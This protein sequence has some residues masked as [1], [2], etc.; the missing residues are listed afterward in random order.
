M[1]EYQ[2]PLVESNCSYLAGELQYHCMDTTELVVRER[3]GDLM[4]ETKGANSKV[5]TVQN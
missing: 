4:I 5:S 2:N 3:S 1:S